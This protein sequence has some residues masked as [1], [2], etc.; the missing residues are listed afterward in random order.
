MALFSA[1]EVPHSEFAYP[2][3]LSNVKEFYEEL[4]TNPH[5]PT[6]SQPAPGDFRRQFQFLASHFRDVLSI[7]LTGTVSGTFEAARSA[8]ERTVAPGTIHEVLDSERRYWHLEDVEGLLARHRASLS[9]VRYRQDKDNYERLTTVE[10]VVQ[11]RSRKRQVKGPG[12]RK[13]AGQAVDAAWGGVAPRIGWLRNE[14][15]RRANSTEG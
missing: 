10:L 14:P 1:E 9:C 15:P 13:S 7:N 2:D 11:R 4:E 6:T 12:S 5:H 3:V 8:A